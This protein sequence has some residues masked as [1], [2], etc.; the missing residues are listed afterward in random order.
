MIFVIDSIPRGIVYHRVVQDLNWL[1][2]SLFVDLNNS[3]KVTRFEEAFSAYIGRKYCV[4][5]PSA[6]IALY[7]S[8]KSLNLPEGSEII[9]PPITIKAILDVVIDLGLTPV[10]VDLDAETLCFDIDLL[11][12]SIG[13]KTRAALVTYLFGMVPDVERMAR[14]LKVRKV[15]MLEDFSQCLDGVYNGLKVGRFGDIGIYSASSIKTLDTFGGGLLVCDKEQ[16]HQNMRLEQGKLG[17]SKR[18]LLIKK[19]VIDLVRNLATTRVIFALFTFPFIKLISRIKP[20][21]MLKHTGGRN[22]EMISVLPKEWFVGYS[23]FQAEVGG[24]LL[25]EVPQGNRERIKNVEKIKQQA[26]DTKFPTG[27]DGAENVYWQLP[28]YFDEP[29]TAQKFLSE[30]GVDTSTTSLELISDLP[31]YPDQ[32]IT[33]V[34]RKIYD[35]G[36]FIP[37]Y[38]GLS[39]G[40]INRICCAL[41]RYSA[42]DRQAD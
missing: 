40:D 34:A 15:Y 1:L 42:Q 41:N 22:K 9:M 23:S 33:P 25:M 3:R 11:E 32:G 38:P 39:D 7:C 21:S 12:K 37:A 13:E 26:P 19:I 30:K 36:L 5:F 10:F 6:R 28:A 20:K 29:Y 14:I 17:K 24:K 4:A 2:R 8:L 35:A 16:A 31:A 27:I 18:L